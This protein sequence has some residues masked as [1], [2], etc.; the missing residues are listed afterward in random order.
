LRY[1][2]GN[3]TLLQ[4]NPEKALEV[5][6][7]LLVYL[8]ISAVV[9]ILFFAIIIYVIL[10]RRVLARK[11]AYKLSQDALLSQ[12]QFRKLY[13]LSPVPY[14]I[15]TQNGIIER[16]NT[17]SLRFLGLSY[18]ELVG[19]DLFT[20]LST[21][22][23]PDKIAIYKEQSGRRVPLEK[24][25]V[26]V[27]PPNKP[28]RWSL[29]SVQDLAGSYGAHKGLATLVDI[30]EQKELDRVK[31]EFLSL[32]SH[33]LRAPLANLKWYIDFLLKRRAETLTQEIAGYLNK[34]Y[35]RNEDMI[36]LVNTLLNL[37][38]IE[39]GRLKV[40]R[41]RV[42][43]T[44]LARSVVEELEPVIIAKNLHFT[45]ELGEPLELETDGKLVRIVLQN[46]FSNAIRYTPQDGS[47]TLRVQSAQ[48]GVDIEVTDTGIGIPLEEQAHI[49]QKLYRAANARQVEVNGN[50]I[51]LYMCK[52]LVESLGGAISFI[53]TP[54]EGTTFTVHLPA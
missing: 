9:A 30:H 17:A 1:F 32:A 7:T 52:S 54:G 44:L 25:E 13:E 45:G 19:K 2:E 35:R 42:D 6:N 39:M 4:N 28:P 33:Q 15:V 40:E 23:H 22:D 3:Q 41:E 5:A 21:P 20:F 24:K 50:G 31:T 29:L 53:S 51:G 34:M 14:I 26:L 10:T 47:L 49:F 18:E 37:S 11:M 16:P 48:G 12:E 43:I 27:S 38:R 46:L 36:E 8:L